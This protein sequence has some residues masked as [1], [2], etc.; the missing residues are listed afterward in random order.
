MVQPRAPPPRAHSA[1][2]EASESEAV[3]PFQRLF[4]QLAGDDAEVSGT[5]LINVLNRV[6]V[7]RPE[8]RWFGY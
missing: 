2:I 1:H 4:T 6:M 3:L 5:E 8:D 7:R